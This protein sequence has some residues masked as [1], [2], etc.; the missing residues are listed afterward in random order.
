MSVQ[1]RLTVD[2]KYNGELRDQ[3]P[4]LD[5]GVASLRAEPYQ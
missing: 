1:V 3:R 5:A 4:A 2:D